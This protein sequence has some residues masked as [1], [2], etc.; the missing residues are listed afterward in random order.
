[1]KIQSRNRVHTR[2]SLRSLS[3]ALLRVPLSTALAFACT[4]SLLC[5]SSLLCISP[6]LCTSIDAQTPSPAST[7]TPE[8][9]RPTIPP[10]GYTSIEPLWP[11][12]APLSTGATSADIPKLYCYPAPGPGP[13]TAVVVLPG[14]GYINLVMEKE[15]AAEARWLNARGVSAYILQY[16]LAPRY[17]YPAPMLDGLRAVRFIR[18]HAQPWH[19]RPDAIGIWGFSAGGHPPA[20]SPPPTL[21]PTRPSPA[22]PTPLRPPVRTP[23]SAPI[24]STP[25]APT[26]PSPSS[27]TAGSRSTPPS[28]A[29][30][31]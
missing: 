26:P 24:R 20:T 27:A 19:L 3:S 12:P 30:S 25:S 17:L 14:G 28:P 21:T 15:G 7:P 23:S 4:G 11:G 16:R 13:H 8:V 6:L 10:T 22:Q 31:A 29:P 18:A 2:F 5:A 9:P 1:M